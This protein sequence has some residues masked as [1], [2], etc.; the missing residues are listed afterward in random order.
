MDKTTSIKKT[1]SNLTN[2]CLE[3]LKYSENEKNEVTNETASLNNVSDVFEN[4]VFGNLEK[5]T[6]RKYR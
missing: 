3:F 1:L 5:L 4:P 6:N 2:L